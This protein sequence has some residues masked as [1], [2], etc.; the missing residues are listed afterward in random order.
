MT[1]KNT[2]F[3][4]IYNSFTATSTEILAPLFENFTHEV[5]LENQKII[6]ISLWD[7]AGRENY[8]ELISLNVT[9]M[10]VC[11]IVFS[12]SDPASFDNALQKV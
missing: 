4:K 11:L 3:S 1:I 7:N 2:K 8:Y 12:V 10:D 5:E 9:M 6:K